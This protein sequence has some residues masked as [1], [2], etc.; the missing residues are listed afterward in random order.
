MKRRGV[1]PHGITDCDR[2][3]AQTNAVDDALDNHHT[4][5]THSH[6]THNDHDSHTSHNTHNTHDTHNSHAS[7]VHVNSDGHIDFNPN[8]IS[9]GGHN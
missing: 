6:D 5:D 2:K 7:T 1:G 3:F 9:H 4:T 8:T